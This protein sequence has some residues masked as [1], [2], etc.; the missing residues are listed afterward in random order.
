MIYCRKGNV[1]LVEIDD[2]YALIDQQSRMVHI[3]NRSAAYAWANLDKAD[4]AFL[5]E[6]SGL[7]VLVDGPTENQVD[8][9]IPPDPGAPAI[10]SSN[11]IQ[12]AA[13]STL[14][15]FEEAGGGRKTFKAVDFNEDG[16]EF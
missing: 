3:L 12:V 4:P 2:N 11:R 10:L 8:L 13:G 16:L 1:F 7:G 6:L 9:E 5:D 14:G 15:D